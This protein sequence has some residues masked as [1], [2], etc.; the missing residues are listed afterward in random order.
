MNPVVMP[1][2]QI[3]YFVAD[4]RAAAL[5]HHQRFGSGPFFVAEHIPLRLSLHRGVARPLDH[6]SACIS[7]PL[8][9]R[10]RPIRTASPGDFRRRHSRGDGT[11]QP[12]P[13]PHGAVRRDERRLR[14]FALVDAAAEAG[15]MLEPYE[16]VPRLT[17]FYDFV[18]QA[19]AGFDGSDPVRRVAMG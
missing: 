6:S 11:F 5:Q 13:M 17:G 10:Q 9:R 1:V 14:V 3:A 18:A 4:V 12:R 15:H 19:A 7:R 8:S 2:Q 16:L